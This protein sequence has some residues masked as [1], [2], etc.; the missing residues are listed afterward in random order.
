[1]NWG[2]DQTKALDSLIKESFTAEKGIKVDLKIV[3]NSLINGLL[4]GD[5]PDLQLHLSR[6]APVDYGM[7]KALADLTQFEDY[8]EVLSRF[9]DGADTPYWHNGSLYAIPDTQSFFIMFYRTDVFEELGLEVP[10][11]WDEFLECATTIQRYNMAVYVP[12]T[13]MASTTTV[14]AGIGSFS[15]YPT[16]MLQNGLDM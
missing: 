12:Y 8:K 5:Y 13:Q 16:L 15:M 4:S 10:T 3:S 6:T 2:R 7:R 9:Q 1:M 14:N 11:N